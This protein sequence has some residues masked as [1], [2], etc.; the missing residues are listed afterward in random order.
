M[1][2]KL[3]FAFFII[4]STF[5]LNLCQNQI[6]SE[7]LDKNDSEVRRIGEFAAQVMTSERVDYTLDEILYAKRVDG[8]DIDFELRVIFKLKRNN[9]CLSPQRCEVSLN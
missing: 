9:E 4:L 8:L 6:I 3:I 1:S 7:V 5:S 2:S